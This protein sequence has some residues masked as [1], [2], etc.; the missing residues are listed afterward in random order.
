[1]M[2][3]IRDATT[4]DGMPAPVNTPTTE[5]EIAPSP[6][7]GDSGGEV[8]VA[9]GVADGAGVFKT[10]EESSPGKPAGKVVLKTSTV[11]EESGD[12]TEVGIISAKPAAVLGK[13]LSTMVVATPTDSIADVVKAAVK[14]TTEDV[15]VGSMGDVTGTAT[16]EDVE[17]DPDADDAGTALIAAV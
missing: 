17:L 11:S 14:L 3:G 10:T 6:E 2:T 13:S 4:E 7:T 16:E 9:G 15:D 5:V 1:M 8:T 12:A